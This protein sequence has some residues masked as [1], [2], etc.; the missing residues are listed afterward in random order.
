[1]AGSF[2]EN[3][4]ELKVNELLSYSRPLTMNGKNRMEIPI[5]EEKIL[6]VCTPSE[7][8]ERKSTKTRFTNVNTNTEK[9]CHVIVPWN[10]ETIVHL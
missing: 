6:I 8:S 5:F 1:M 10:Y 4:G 2:L 9:V 7:F 3:L